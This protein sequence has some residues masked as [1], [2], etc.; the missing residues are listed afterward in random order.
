MFQNINI[1]LFYVCV[2][3]MKLLIRFSERFFH[4]VVV[5]VVVL[6]L[7]DLIYFIKENL[8]LLFF[9][10]QKKKY[11]TN[12]ENI[13]KRKNKVKMFEK[14]SLLLRRMADHI[15]FSFHFFCRVLLL[16]VRGIYRRK[17][18]KKRFYLSLIF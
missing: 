9:F 13:S 1:Y 6:L 17:I 2:C 12:S 10:L 5:V 18:F 3:E 16:R 15:V 8:S 11:K 14:I 7:D 4:V